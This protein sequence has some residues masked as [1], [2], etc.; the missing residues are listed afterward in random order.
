MK[1]I[2]D[3]SLTPKEFSDGVHSSSI[4]GSGTRL[5]SSALKG[6]HVEATVCA[7]VLAQKPQEG[8]KSLG[9]PVLCGLGS[10]LCRIWKVSTEG[11]HENTCK[12]G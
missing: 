4:Q 3:H 7:R 12:M 2:G 10:S 1:D 5:S 11:R 9:E 6:A 8:V